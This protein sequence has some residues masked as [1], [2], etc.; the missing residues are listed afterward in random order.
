MWTVPWEM[1]KMDII[2]YKKMNEID[3]AI[4]LYE[5]FSVIMNKMVS[6]FYHI[7][8]SMWG[9]NKMNMTIF[10]GNQ[11]SVGEQMKQ[12]YSYLIMIFPL[13]KL[14]HK[15]RFDINGHSVK[16]YLPRLIQNLT[17]PS[18][19]HWVTSIGDGAWIS[20]DIRIKGWNVISHPCANF[21]GGWVNNRRI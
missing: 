15:R 3:I 17:W 12:L 19:T 6:P 4:L 14:F 16:S 5:P 13:R 2:I 10:L 20:S 1:N 9:I 18:F 7:C 21:N 11:F 8:R